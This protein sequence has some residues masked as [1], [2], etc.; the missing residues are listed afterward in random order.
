[1]ARIYIHHELSYA[2]DSVIARPQAARGNPAGL[3]V[4]WRA[5]WLDCFAR[6]VLGWVVNKCE[7]CNNAGSAKEATEQGG[8][9]L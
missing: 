1:M 2:L 9:L 6:G 4:S 8:A 5:A 3:A 7:S